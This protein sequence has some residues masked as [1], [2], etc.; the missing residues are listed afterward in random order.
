M[1]RHR[2]IVIA[3]A[4]A[5]GVAVV[6]GP[7]QAADSPAPSAGAHGASTTPA[8]KISS[9]AF[10][11][12]SSPV[13]ASV[14]KPR[15]A[16][17]AAQNGPA[18]QETT[19]APAATPNLGTS[20]LV[21]GTTAY[22][23]SLKADIVSDPVAVNVVISWGDGTTTQ[24]FTN[25]TS[26]VERTHTYA[27]L[28]VYDVKVE[29]STATA[30]A[31]NGVT[32]ATPGSAYT[33]AG[34]ARLLDTRD[35][36]GVDSAAKVLP[37]HSVRVK[38]AG[39]AGVP[40]GATA[41]ALNITVTDPVGGAGHIIAFPDGTERPTT[42]NVNYT[43]GQ[44]VP[45]L[46]IVP[47]GA[48]GYVTLYNRGAASVNLIADI[49]GYFSHAPAAGY[50]G[51]SPTRV[52]DTR[53]GLGTARGQVAGWASFPV[54]VRGAAGVPYG[55]KAVALN[56]TVTDPKTDGHLTVYPGG[57]GAPTASNV[58]F[59]AG[60]TV[61]NSV[62][63]PIGA[64]GRIQVLN[65][66][67]GASDVIVDVVGYY[68]DDS[69]SAFLPVLPLRLLDTR[70]ASWGFG[71]LPGQNYIYMPLSDG[72]PQF[73]GF[74]LNSTVTNTKDAGHL[75]VFPDPNSI[76][77]YNNGTAT[78]PAK[79]NTSTLNWKA[80]DTVPNLVQANP[81][82]NGIVDFWNASGGDIDLVVDMFGVYQDN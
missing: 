37:D 65:G 55:A 69:K 73:T 49:A 45:N 32:I 70:E 40:A 47:V 39:N 34:P 36:T 26:T 80:G 8:N 38:I 20:V 50:T 54:Q 3:A 23:V 10:K 22:G 74:V 31:S 61:A 41:V 28:G 17:P 56:V 43:E 21:Q 59:R 78:V 71:P 62:I 29:L 6:P 46:A 27:K 7:A 33:P 1:P 4:V 5:A 2:L 19:G 15:A 75:T 79:P 18:A 16:A 30:T 66:A 25:G 9:S 14:A 42:S 67:A 12:V 68:S 57:Q 64:D 77:R 53:E 60:Q 82:A 63:V 11:T 48:D 58:N 51:V 72:H 13:E 76:D 35:G 44:T 24:V 52:V 81:G